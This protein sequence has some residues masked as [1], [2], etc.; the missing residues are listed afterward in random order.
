MN[1]FYVGQTVALTSRSMP[2]K[3]GIYVVSSVQSV[4]SDA[5]YDRTGEDATGFAY[6]LSGLPGMWAER[7]LSEM[8]NA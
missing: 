5:V 2:E 4:P 3:N 7:S 8:G 6:S 1:K